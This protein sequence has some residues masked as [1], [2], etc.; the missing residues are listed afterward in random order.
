MPIN[1][2]QLKITED[3][4]TNFKSIV[5]TISLKIFSSADPNSDFFRMRLSASGN[6]EIVRKGNPTP[7]TLVNASNFIPSSSFSANSIEIDR[8]KKPSSPSP[9][10]VLGLNAS[11]NLEYMDMAR[12]LTVT[13]GSTAFNNIRSLTFDGYPLES[14]SEGIAKF[15][16]PP[17]SVGKD[18]SPYLGGDLNTSKGIGPSSLVRT[19]PSSL[20]ISYSALTGIL[21]HPS[22]NFLS[23]PEVQAGDIIHLVV[24]SE[25][26]GYV[27]IESVSNL[28]LTLPRLAFEEISP[29]SFVEYSIYRAPSFKIFNSLDNIASLNLSEANIKRRT[30]RIE[31]ADISLSNYGK[32]RLGA[33][34]EQIYVSTTRNSTVYK[35]SLTLS[36]AGLRIYTQST[37]GPTVVS[38]AIILRPLSSNGGSRS[39]LFSENGLSFSP[40]KLKNVLAEELSNQDPLSSVWSGVAGN[41]VANS[42]LAYNQN[43]RFPQ[44]YTIQ[45]VLK[46]LPG[47]GNSKMLR[48]DTNGDINWSGS[49]S[50]V[51]YF[52]S[53]GDAQTA[54][55]SLGLGT[56]AII[57]LTGSNELFLCFK[58]LNNQW[59]QLHF[60]SS[61]TVDYSSIRTDSQIGT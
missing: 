39:I 34:P 58:V 18:G 17:F 28:F 54:A 10:K 15:G 57:T 33:V 45:D 16:L 51:A 46:R 27:E 11:S 59:M 9:F 23:N 56:M 4:R 52:A 48:S 6:I 43:G 41:S 25:D 60:T 44:F 30:V 49:D 19:S 22:A 1:N 53:S 31:N 26:K 24:D 8:L 5:D 3:F 12:P 37:S 38:G 40:I 32:L 21:S 2:K 7:L 36:D 50:V 47:F 55:P 20:G 61:D 13:N 35:S 29:S 42:I 14:L